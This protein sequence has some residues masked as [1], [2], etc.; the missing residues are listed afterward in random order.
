MKDQHFELENYRGPLDL[1]LHLIREHEME[2]TEVSLASLCDQYLA[3]ID[4]MR[5]LDVNVAGEFL[6]TAATLMLI[7]SR[8]ILPTEEV[9]LEEELDPGDELILQ[10]LEYR[11]YKTL[12]LELKRRQEQRTLRATQGL[13]DMPAPDEPELEEVELWDVVNL[14]ARLV[15]ELGLRR[16]FDT[17]RHEKPL[18]EYMSVVVDCLLEEGSWEFARLVDLQGGRESLFPVFLSVLE[19]TRTGQVNVTQDSTGGT[20]VVELRQDRDQDRLD[21]LFGEIEAEEKATEAD[22]A[23]ASEDDEPRETVAQQDDEQDVEPVAAEPDEPQ[24]EG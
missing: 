3:A 14:Y 23:E 16:R 17:M 22:E 1:L 10:L 6:V 13:R 12:A 7:K 15:E 4:E 9:D 19:L 11:K 5:D 21:A 18:K 20:I 2:I 8:T 24:A